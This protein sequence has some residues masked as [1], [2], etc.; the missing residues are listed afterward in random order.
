MPPAVPRCKFVRRRLPV[1]RCATGYVRNGC[2]VLWRPQHYLFYA[3]NLHQP[4]YPS[5][6]GGTH[7]PDVE[8]NNV[9]LLDFGRRESH[10]TGRAKVFPEAPATYACVVL[11]SNIVGALD[12]SRKT[13][14]SFFLQKREQIS[15][16]RNKRNSRPGR[17]LGSYRRFATFLTRWQQSKNEAPHLCGCQ[18]RSRR[19]MQITARV[20]ICVGTSGTRP[21]GESPLFTRRQ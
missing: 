17:R 16:W 13:H 19:A 8:R 3:I 4:I 5:W 21:D 18:V 15:I 1:L 2:V 6:Y 7:T 9:G 20:N 10:H 11:S 14:P 12:A